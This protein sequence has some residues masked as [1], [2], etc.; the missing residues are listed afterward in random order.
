[1]QYLF[2]L[3]CKLPSFS[4]PWLY[5]VI[6]DTGGPWLYIYDTWALDCSRQPGALNYSQHLGPWIIMTPDNQMALDYSIH[7]RALTI[8][9]TTPGGPWTSRVTTPE[10]LD[11]PQ[12]NASIDCS[13]VCTCKQKFMFPFPFWN[14]RCQTCENKNGHVR[15]QARVR[16]KWWQ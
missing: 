13:Q 11:Y 2:D 6:H 5:S 14:I 3:H 15:T 10:G 9:F 7:R 4:G 1:M 8:L 12:C 16:P